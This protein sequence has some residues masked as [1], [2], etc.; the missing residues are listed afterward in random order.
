MKTKSSNSEKSGQSGMSALEEQVIGALK[1]AAEDSN[2]DVRR[3]AI[4]SLRK[5]GAFSS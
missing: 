5:L 2:G 1:N 3:K 4:K